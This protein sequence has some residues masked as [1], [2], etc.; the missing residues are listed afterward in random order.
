[1]SNKLAKLLEKEGLFSKKQFKER[2]KQARREGRYLTPVLLEQPDLPSDKTLKI[3]A[4]FFD[5]PTVDLKE[6]RIAPAVG[7]RLM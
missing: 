5:L 2:V 1:M 7:L 6:R 3:L 4:D